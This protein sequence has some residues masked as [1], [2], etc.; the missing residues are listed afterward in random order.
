M[1]KLTVEEIN[2]L[3]NINIWRVKSFR[4]NVQIDFDEYGNILDICVT[5]S[6]SSQD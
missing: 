2:K 3:L 5:N 6:E 4:A 1:D